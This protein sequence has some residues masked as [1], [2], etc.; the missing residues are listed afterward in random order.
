[1]YKNKDILCHFVLERKKK[2]SRQ[3]RLDIKKDKKY[4]KNI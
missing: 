3:K 4:N 2:A 1:M